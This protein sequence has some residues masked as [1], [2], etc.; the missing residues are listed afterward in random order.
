[1][2]KVFTLLLLAGVLFSSNVFAQEAT[3]AATTE[4]VAADE[5]VAARLLPILLLRLTK[6]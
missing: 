6:L 3:E 2:K 1:M 4:T 5:T